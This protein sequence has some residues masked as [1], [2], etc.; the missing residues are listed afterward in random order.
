[1]RLLTLNVKLGE[2]VVLLEPRCA[3]VGHVIHQAPQLLLVMPY[4]SNKAEQ[5][6]RISKEYTQ[7]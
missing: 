3:V 4:K 6:T 7:Q 1:M 5:G 2:G